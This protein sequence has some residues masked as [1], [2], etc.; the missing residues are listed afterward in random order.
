MDS[1]TSKRFLLQ[2]LRRRGRQEGCM[3][4]LQARVDLLVRIHRVRLSDRRAPRL[5]QFFF[6]IYS[7]DSILMSNTACL[8]PPPGDPAGDPV[9]RIAGG[10][11]FWHDRGLHRPMLH[12]MHRLGCRILQPLRIVSVAFAPLLASNDIDLMRALAASRL[13]STARRTSR[14]PRTLGDS[15]KTAVSPR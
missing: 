11:L 3:G 15:S 8:R 2:L 13:R 1:L 5:V 12:R 7:P 10:Q 6:S 4:C 9:V 14:P